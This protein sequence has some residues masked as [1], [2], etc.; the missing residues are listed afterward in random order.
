MV[1]AGDTGKLFRGI[2]G[3][4]RLERYA[5]IFM[6]EEVVHANEAEVVKACNE[7]FPPAGYN[8]RSIAAWTYNCNL[9]EKKYGGDIRSFFEEK[10]NSAQEVIDA[11]V[12]YPRAKTEVKKARG[13]FLRYGVKLSRLL[14]QWIHQYQLY[15]LK[16]AEEIGLP[17]DF[18]I[19]RIMIQTGGLE[20]DGPAQ[21]HHLTYDVLLPLLTLLCSENEWSSQEVSETLW[22]IGSLCCNRQ[23]HNLCPVEDM[24]DRL[25]SRRPYDRRGLFDPR[26][27]GRFK[28][29]K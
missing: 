3:P 22:L 27:V 28:A 1:F 26:D 23:R 11:L 16:G 12:V 8:N 17:V 6:P 9:L 13:A 10:G 21:A 25:I 20:L 18:Q 15:E 4:G 7:F 5:W 19:G 14:V 24:C 2:S 29:T